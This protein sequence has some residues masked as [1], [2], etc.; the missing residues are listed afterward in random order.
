MS[1]F[2][3]ITLRY[4]HGGV[5]NSKSK[6]PD[7]EGS[8]VTNIFDVDKLSYF[9]LTGFLKELGYATTRCTFYLRPPKKDFLLSF[10][11]D[12]DIFELSQSFENG[13]IVEVYV[14]YIVDQLDKVDGPIGLLEYTTTNEKSFVAFNK[15]GDKGVHEGD[16][17][18]EKRVESGHFNEAPTTAAYVEVEN[19]A[20]LG[21]ASSTGFVT[22]GGKAAVGGEVAATVEAAPGEASSAGVVAAGHEA[23]AGGKVTDTSEAVNTDTSDLSTKNSSDSDHEDIFVEDDA[24]FKSDVHEEDINLRAKRRKYQ[25]RK[26]KERIPNDP[27]KVSVGEGRPRSTSPTP[28]DAPPRPRGGPR[29]TSDN[30]DAPPRPRGRPRKTT[31]AAP[32]VNI[33]YVTAA[34]RGKGRGIGHIEYVTAVTRG[35]EKGIEHIEHVAATVRGRGMSVKYASAAV[36]GKRR[37]IEHVAATVRG[38]GRRRGRGK[39]VEHATV[40]TRGRRWGVEHAA[41]TARGRGRGVEHTAAAVRRRKRGVEH[42]AAAAVPGRGRGR[43]RKTPLSDIGVTRRTTPLHEWFENQ[44]SYAPPNPPASPVYAPP[45][46]SASPVHTSPNP[47]A[48]IGKRPMIVGIGV[49]IAENGFTTYNLELPSNRILHTGSAHPIRSADITKGLGYKPKIRVRWRGKKAMNGNQLEVMRD[50][51]IMNKR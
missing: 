41:A 20:T 39:G 28:T 4:F 6:K 31:P 14:F 40:A 2:T 9:E 32:A 47:H 10:Q 19:E 8:E 44:T 50:E 17:V 42:A 21:E 34:T 29:K 45:N 26:R 11:C 12:E 15:E 35:R 46:L 37:S 22:A 3:Y 13:D 51:M 33:K 5:L 43:P 30:L 18:V 7:Y 23:A 16:R 48:S 25:R 49:L 1:D 38:R 24:E 36:R 27:T